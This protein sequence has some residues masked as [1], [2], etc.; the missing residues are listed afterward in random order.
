[1]AM[2]RLR[3]VDMASM[4]SKETFNPGRIQGDVVVYELATQNLVGAYPFDST[5]PD[6]LKST[7]ESK[8]RELDSTLASYATS[9]IK[10]GLT[11][12]P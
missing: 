3:T 6:E 1:M 11:S 12:A 10:A 7:W 5:L 2:I 4:A 9:D 8:E